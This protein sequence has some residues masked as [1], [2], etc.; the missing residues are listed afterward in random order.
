MTTIKITEFHPPGYVP[1]I[2]VRRAEGVTTVFVQGDASGISWLSPA[3][4]REVIAAL[5]AAVDE[6]EPPTHEAWKAR[7]R[8]WLLDRAAA[9][10]RDQLG[11]DA[12]LALSQAADDLQPPYVP[13]G[14][15][16]PPRER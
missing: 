10:P 6:V 4:A 11:G 12:H 13:A 16:L 5:Q 14:A 7:A 9:F 8:E 2:I 15:V 3:K 1:E